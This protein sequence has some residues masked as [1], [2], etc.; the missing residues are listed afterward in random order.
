MQDTKVCHFCGEDIKAIAIKCKHCGSMLNEPIPTTA[1]I[2]P[3]GTTIQMALGIN[4]DVLD[5]L[6]RGGM[7]TVYRAIQ[8]NLNREVALKVL[9]P[10][11]NHDTEFIERFH[12]E[13]R[14]AASLTHPNIITI[15]DEG[16]ISG[17]HFM[18]MA[19]V[20]GEDLHNRV[21]RE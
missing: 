20:T 2:P 8:K 21:K 11:Y 14:S 7:A 15:Y 13:A 19:L 3:Q 10:H 16:T 9:A 4:Y 12:R 17:V 5:E 6:G 1:H 18:A